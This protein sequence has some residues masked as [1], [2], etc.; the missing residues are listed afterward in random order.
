MLKPT[1]HTKYLRLYK[2]IPDGS[3][4]PALFIT[5]YSKYHS[6]HILIDAE[7]AGQAAVKCCIGKGVEEVKFQ[8]GWVEVFF[9]TLHYLNMAGCTK[10]HAAAGSQDVMVCGFK[11][12]HQAQVD[13]F[14][15]FNRA[16]GAVAV[17]YG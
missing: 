8:I 9:R 1:G 3:S 4:K 6:I 2:K 12:F 10:G 7:L 14:W 5:P 16:A 11:H 13:I 17:F 15:Y